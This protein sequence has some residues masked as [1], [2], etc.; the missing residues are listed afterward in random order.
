MED[1]ITHAHVLF[2]PNNSSPPLPPAPSGEPVP[3]ISYGSS[4]TKVSEMPPPSL[5]RAPSP[6]RRIHDQFAQSAQLPPS[7]SARRSLDRP[8]IERPSIERPC[9][10]RPSIERP[11]I[12]R[13]SI[14]RPAQGPEDF[15]P[16]LPPRPV[17]SIHPSLRAGPSGAPV[18]QSLPPP[19]RSAQWFDESFTLD[20]A[21]PRLQGPPSVPPSPR[22]I[23]RTAPT[24]LSLK[25]PW[26]D[27][28]PSLA[29]TVLSTAPPTNVSSTSI[30]SEETRG[31]EANVVFLNDAPVSAPSTGLSFTTAISPTPSI[32]SAGR[33]TPSTPPLSAKSSILGGSPGGASISNKSLR[34]HRKDGSSSSE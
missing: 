12:E 20:G 32:S 7:I 11:S 16:Q 29:S 26:S 6:D 24:P 14:E 4:H 30:D 34:Q 25:S 31:Q 33:R 1:L 28:Q 3:T 27:S 8:S 23:Q 5:L 18:R 13:P 9:I 2:Q 22:R 21:T 17:N 10:E 15:T 19:P